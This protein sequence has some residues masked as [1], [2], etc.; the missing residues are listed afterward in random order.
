[1]SSVETM[2]TWEVEI[3]NYIN[4][5][6]TFKEALHEFSEQN[7]SFPFT[8]YLPENSS[9]SSNR[10]S[11]KLIS[12]FNK[13]IH[14][15][16]KCDNKLE[17]TCFKLQDIDYLKKGTVLLRSWIIINGISNGN[18]SSIKIDYNTVN[19]KIFNKLL[20]LL[21]FGENVI[22]TSND[23]E[24]ISMLH[25]LE[26]LDY[27]YFNCSKANLLNN[28]HLVYSIYQCEICKKIAKSINFRI[29]PTHN[30][31]LTDKELII[32][33]EEYH[34][35]KNKSDY[36]TICSYIPIG[37][38]KDIEIQHNE[39]KNIYTCTI[40]IK[41]RNFIKLLYEPSNQEKLQL[42][43]QKSILFPI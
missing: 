3:E 8:I 19:D 32:I 21:R 11:A 25:Y 6:E 17:E 5:P 2:R 26:A 29:F 24:G 34:K 27:K 33:S 43:K 38:I 14:I 12:V 15:Y 30:T 41:D 35:I 31:M 36:G 40:N 9:K 13:K 16:D 18:K 28:S 22:E 39:V 23:Q 42:L 1:M 4:L 7:Y 20:Y 37:N 10:R